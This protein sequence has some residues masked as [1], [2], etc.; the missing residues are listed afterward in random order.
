VLQKDE[1]RKATTIELDESGNI[2]AGSA[3]RGALY[4][5]PTGNLLIRNVLRPNTK[6]CA[7]GITYLPWEDEGVRGIIIKDL[8]NREIAR[9]GALGTG[10]GE[11][12]GCT[13]GGMAASTGPPG[14]PDYLFYAD[15]HN[16]RIGVLR[17]D[18]ASTAA[19]S[20]GK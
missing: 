16:H 1:L 15:L 5:G 3:G 13:P 12:A 19:I 10:D 11:F 4:D 14:K 8:K 20:T 17:V 2:W 6:A 18:W 7:G 9:K